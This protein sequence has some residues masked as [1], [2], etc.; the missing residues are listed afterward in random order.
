MTSRT[1]TVFSV[2]AVLAALV[3][4]ARVPAARPPDTFPGP[5]IAAP[6][7]PLPAAGE[8]VAETAIGW[9]GVPYRNG[10]SDPSGFDCSGFV[11]YVFGELGIRLPRG[12][13]EQL[14]AG[15]H[16]GEDVIAAGDLVFF[17]TTGTGA[18]HVG[19]ASGPDAFVHSPSTGGQVRVDR[20]S[21]PYWSKRFLEARRIVTGSDVRLR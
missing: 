11:Q 4:C 19:I 10:G 2:A 20:L 14:R 3:G 8:T 13:E 9:V 16:V 7:D 17:A 1:P 18:S 15:R 21:A 5:L 6:A 12:V